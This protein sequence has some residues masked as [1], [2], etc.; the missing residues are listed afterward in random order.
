MFIKRTNGLK[1]FGFKNGNYTVYSTLGFGE[2]DMML[3]DAKR[4]NRLTK[5]LGD[6]EYAVFPVA[7]PV[8][9][10]LLVVGHN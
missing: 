9:H 3:R 2:V 6:R 10:A 1:Q 7:G 8:N 5:K 4:L